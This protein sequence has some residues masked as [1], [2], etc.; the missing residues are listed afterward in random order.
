MLT[1]VAKDQSHMNDT[2]SI[3]CLFTKR[4]HSVDNVYLKMASKSAHEMHESPNA[5]SA[6]T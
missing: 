4:D 2:E 3:K 5:S 6:S 1:R